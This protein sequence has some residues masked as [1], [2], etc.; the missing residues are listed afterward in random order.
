MLSAKL[1]DTEFQQEAVA[2]DNNNDNNE[3][4]EDVED[5]TLNIDENNKH[6]LLTQMSES[7]SY[8]D[9]FTIYPMY[10]KRVKES[11]IALY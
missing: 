9:Q 6:A 10:D 5:E 11:G 7:G 2:N 4:T 8:Y 3:S 1:P